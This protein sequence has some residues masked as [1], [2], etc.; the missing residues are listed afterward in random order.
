MFFA[1]VIILVPVVPG[2]SIDTARS[3]R[4]G[5]IV[6][7]DVCQCFITYGPC[8]VPY[9]AEQ[10]YKWNRDSVRKTVSSVEKWAVKPE[11][12]YFRFFVYSGLWFREQYFAVT[13]LF[14]SFYNK[15]AL[16][17]I[18]RLVDVLWCIGSTIN[19][20]T[21]TK[22]GYSYLKFLKWFLIVLLKKQFE[23]TILT[24]RLKRTEKYNLELFSERGQFN[25]NVNFPT[26]YRTARLSRYLTR[27]NNLP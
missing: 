4:H 3:L 10:R 14:H 9:R 19:H 25:R 8:V 2:S 5:L 15:T 6:A 24:N 13:L 17:K 16:S 20:E 1:V 27:F 26:N 11:S 18:Y 23:N 7:D 22:F 12:Q 21:T